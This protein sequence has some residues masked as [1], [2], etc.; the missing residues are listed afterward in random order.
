[1]ESRKTQ[2]L[3]DK[4]LDATYWNNRYK[5]ERTGWDVG[6]HNPIHTDYIEQNYPKD[7]FILEPGAGN[8]YE[9]EYLWKQGYK[10]V[11]GCDFAP[12]IK[13]RFLKRV[14]DFP[15]NQ[16]L[17][18]DFFSITS[19]FDV[20]LEQ[21]FFCAIDPSLRSKYVQHMHNILKPNGKIYGVLF[22]MDKTDGPPFGGTTDEYRRL[23]SPK[24][25]IA[26]MEK[27][28]KSIP[29]MEHFVLHIKI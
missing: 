13:E 16:Y 27:S 18:G 5:E 14:P 20:V 4:S 19:H 11:Y 9:V 28:T 21:T 17:S 23:F 22:E 8:A 29:K 26:R 1:M 12:E 10:N 15:E 3:K 7:A 24:F 25:E 2:I 6:Y